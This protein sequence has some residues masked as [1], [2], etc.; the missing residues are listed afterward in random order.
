MAKMPPNLLAATTSSSTRTKTAPEA[1]GD[2]NNDGTLDWAIGVSHDQT[3]GQDAGSALVPLGPVSGTVSS[4]AAD[5]FILGTAGTTRLGD[6]YT[7]MFAADL[8]LSRH[9][10]PRDRGLLSAFSARFV[11]GGSQRRPAAE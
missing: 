7:R 10:R 3:A 11:S 6:C 2:W 1:M 4:T 9:H 8:D 5:V